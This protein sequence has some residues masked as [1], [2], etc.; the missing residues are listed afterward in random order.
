METNQTL[1]LR[2]PD[3][4]HLHL[5]DGNVL[6]TVLPYTANLF[7]RAIIMPNLKP[8]ITTVDAAKAYQAEIMENLPESSHFEP[9]MTCYLTDTLQPDE[10]K[11]GAT[12]NVFTAAKLY[13]AGATTNSEHGVTA[14]RNIWPVLEA[15]QEVGLPL[16]MH[17]EVVD[18]TVDIF[19]REAVFIE[20]VLSPLLSDFPELRVVF[21]HI[22]TDAAVQFVLSQ[23][24]R[25]GATI[26]PHHLMINRNAIFQGGIRPHMYCLPVAKREKHRLALR[27]AA[28]SGDPHFF[29]GTDSA[30]HLIHLKEA[31]C[32][33]AGIFNSPTTMPCLAQVFEEEQALSQLEAFASLNGANFY[34]LPI[35]ED[36]ITLKRVAPTVPSDAEIIGAGQKIRIFIPPEGLAWR[37]QEF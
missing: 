20:R 3:D 29:L 17:G 15:M 34:K 13:P 12:E 26:T 21:E 10:I 25:V 2:R 22:T 23:P 36:Y 31:D 35:N 11:R 1:T 37:V 5:R 16:L 32:G 27:Q 7:G 19:D 9:L 18:P 33:C 14:V 28:T 6:K 4:W 30:P 24:E 8:P